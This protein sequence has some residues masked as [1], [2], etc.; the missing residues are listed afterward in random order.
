MVDKMINLDRRWGPWSGRVWG[1]ILNFITNGLAIYGAIGM[2]R[3]GS[4]VPIFIIG[5]ILTI[6]CIALLARPNTPN[7]GSG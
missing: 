1:L 5:L 2:I 6:A 3:D 7:G 4:R